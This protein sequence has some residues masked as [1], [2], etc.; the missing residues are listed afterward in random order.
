MA[1][2]SSCGAESSGAFC[3]ACGTRI[4]AAEN[5]ER[6]ASGVE[7]ARPSTARIGVVGSIAAGVGAFCPLL[8]IMGRRITYIANGHG[9]GMVVVGLAII[10]FLAARLRGRVVTAGAGIAILVLLYNLYNREV[11][12][13][14]RI[15]GAAAG[16]TG[17]FSGF[18]HQLADSVSI[19]WGL[20]LMAAGAAL[21]IVSPL[22]PRRRVPS[23]APE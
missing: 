21:M 15:Q 9:D 23:I 12:A 3:T 7:S 8:D 13:I 19:D 14:A 1:V 5:V 11:A 22:V 20:Y 2:C 17:M 4:I 10:G 16:A 6:A 18:A